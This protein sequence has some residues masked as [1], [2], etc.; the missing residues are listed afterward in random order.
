MIWK[1]LALLRSKT[2]LT[3]LVFAVLII[4]IA[5][6]L[7]M[8]LLPPTGRVIY[9]TFYP[10]IALIAL[11]CGFRVAIVGML[12]A[13][14]LA[15]LFLLPPLNELKT[16]NLEAAIGLATYF[17]AATIICLALREVDERGKRIR[18]IN[19]RLEDLLST[20][21]VGKTLAGLV[22]IIA[23]TIEVRD[24]YTIGH[25]RKVSQL[26]TAIAKKLQLSDLTVMGIQLAG[27]ILDLGKLYVPVVVLNRSAKLTPEEMAMVRQHPKAAYEVLKNLASPWPL[28]EMIYQHHERL[29]GTGYPNQLQGNYILI[30]AR[31]LAVADVVEAMTARR[32]YRESLGLEAALE[33]ITRGK[34]TKYDATVVNA[35]IDLFRFDGFK[36]KD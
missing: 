3:Q 27:M 7:R 35:C 17:I 25:Q 29:D 10:A 31:I 19:D 24:P 21:E 28:A 13:G 20:H 36:W 12:F 6:S 5:F 23:T 32:P 18:I 2:T 30:E 22:E 9:S 16:L 11:M 14:V 4:G 34:N 1:N 33:E 15:Y 26:A 8:V